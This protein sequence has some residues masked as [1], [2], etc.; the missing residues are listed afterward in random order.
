M[1][2]QNLF[3]VKSTIKLYIKVLLCTYLD[4]DN[5]SDGNVTL[6]INKDIF[7]TIRNAIIDLLAVDEK[8]IDENYIEKM[9]QPPFNSHKILLLHLFKEQITSEIKDQHRND[10]RNNPERRIPFMEVIQENNIHILNMKV[11][12]IKS[13]KKIEK[14]Q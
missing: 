2:S 4:Y 5:I 3:R 1:D 12:S 9:I 11:E 13:I 8:S 10:C 6:D 7:L 14:K